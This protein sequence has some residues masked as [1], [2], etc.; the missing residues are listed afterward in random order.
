M[1][2]LTREEYDVL[3]SQTVISSPLVDHF[4]PALEG[5]RGTSARRSWAARLHLHVR[6]NLELSLEHSHFIR[7][8]LLNS[9]GRKVPSEEPVWR[10]KP[11]PRLIGFIEFS[12]FV[13]HPFK[14]E[15]PLQTFR[16]RFGLARVP[17]GNRLRGGAKEVSNF[18]TL[19]P[20]AFPDSL[21]SNS[22]GV[23]NLSAISTYQA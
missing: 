22:L 4:F 7:V 10:K 18:S 15:E 11:K 23:A 9:I 2:Q 19:D 14:N 21:K 16:L 17:T 3:R 13:D 1:F 8:S 20:A 12:E 6:P 5:N